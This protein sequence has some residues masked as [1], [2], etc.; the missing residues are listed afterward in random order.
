LVL[1]DENGAELRQKLV[2]RREDGNRYG[3]QVVNLAPR[4]AEHRYWQIGFSDAE[5]S[6]AR[7]ARK[8]FI[9]FRSGR[10]KRL[11][12]VFVGNVPPDNCGN[13]ATE[14]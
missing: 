12:R 13:E 3:E 14:S 2:M 11:Q 9:E 5:L 4:H 1:S 6:K 10:R 8:A 7:A